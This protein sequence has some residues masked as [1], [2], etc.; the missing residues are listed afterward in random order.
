MARAKITVLKRTVMQDIAEAHM[1]KEF[2]EREGGIVCPVF[3]EGGRVHSR[4]RGQGSGWIQP[5][6]V[7]RHSQVHPDDHGRRRV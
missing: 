5:L 3:A 1:G 4:F 6:G 7:V 2:L